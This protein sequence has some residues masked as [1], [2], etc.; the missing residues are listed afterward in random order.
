M[1]GL[2]GYFS[3]LHAQMK[4]LVKRLFEAAEAGNRASARA[5]IVDSRG[6]VVR[7]AQK[8]QTFLSVSQV[9]E[10]MVRYEA[11]EGIK[12]L[13]VEYGVHRSTLWRHAVR[14][15]VIAA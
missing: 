12:K 14:R 3:N 13:A 11:G 9:D 2:S 7:N 6:R 5:E 4:H 8:V 15:G 1:V 10:A